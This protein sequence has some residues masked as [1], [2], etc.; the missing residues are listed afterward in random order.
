MQLTDT[1]T[2]VTRGTILA[3]KIHLHSIEKV[4]TGSWHEW[5]EILKTKNNL[6]SS[7]VEKQ[8]DISKTFLGF[9]LIYGKN[10]ISKRTWLI[11]LPSPCPI[12]DKVWFSFSPVGQLAGRGCSSKA[13]LYR[14]HCEVHEMDGLVEKFCYCSFNLCNT[15]SLEKVNLFVYEKIIIIHFILSLF[16]IGF[17]T[18][19]ASGA[20]AT[21]S[22]KSPSFLTVIMC[23][24]SQD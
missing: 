13:K 5:L 22:Y 23:A 8:N 7:K 6:R 2:H 3:Q 15:S 18:L 21:I 24:C 19:H 20:F 16:L 14:E 10:Q 12:D 11:N 4:F 17:P 9:D 1:Y